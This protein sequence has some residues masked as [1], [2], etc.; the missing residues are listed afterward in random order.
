MNIHCVNLK[1][2]D[3]LRRSDDRN[4]PIKTLEMDNCYD[5]CNYLKINILIKMFTNLKDL[6]F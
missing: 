5:S 6:C 3:T 2:N 4:W 1:M